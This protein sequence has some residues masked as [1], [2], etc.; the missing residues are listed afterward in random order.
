MLGNAGKRQGPAG[1]IELT[2]RRLFEEISQASEFAFKIKFSYFEIYNEQVRDLLA[3]GSRSLMIIEIGVFVNELSEHSI[4]NSE[5]VLDL[6]AQGNRA[7]PWPRQAQISSP[8]DRMHSFNSESS[9]GRLLPLGGSPS[10]LPNF[11]WST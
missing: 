2:M 3:Q 10:S 5:T 8:P 11:F 4:G 6:I 1:L 7:G 9:G